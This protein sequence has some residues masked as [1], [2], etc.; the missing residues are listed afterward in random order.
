M[1]FG[2]EVMVGI[3]DKVH[4]SLSRPVTPAVYSRQYPPNSSPCSVR[5]KMLK[6]LYKSAVT[7]STLIIMILKIWCLPVNLQLHQ[8]IINTVTHKAIIIYQ[9]KTMTYLYII[10]TNLKLKPCVKGPW[11]HP[12]LDWNPSKSHYQIHYV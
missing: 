11:N 7:V 12:N 4:C 2:I 6:Y 8:V 5:K 10:F 9:P 1:P 3:S